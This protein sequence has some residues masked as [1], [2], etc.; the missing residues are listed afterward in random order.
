MTNSRLEPWQQRVV[1]EKDELDKRLERLRF[2]LECHPG[3]SAAQRD[4]MSRQASYMSAY[5]CTLRDRI[6]L[7]GEA[8]D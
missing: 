1:D 5:S 8:S 3:I 7:F 4:L 2:A 6:E